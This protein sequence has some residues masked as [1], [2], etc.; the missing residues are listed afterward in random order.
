MIISAIVARGVNHVIGIN[1]NLPWHLPKD[2]KWFKEKTK[3]HHVIMG[4]KSFDSLGQPLPQRVNIVITRDR[5]FAHTGV[6]VVHTIAEA[7]HLAAVAGE[8]EAFILGGGKIYKQ[9]VDLWDRLYLT[10]V[11]ASPEGDTFFP[12]IDDDRYVTTYEEHHKQDDRH[13]Y[14]FVFKILERK[15]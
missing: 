10:E 3:G 11:A 9:T 14:D 4:R 1:N 6:E 13:A 7:L 12:L 5:N 8:E 15:R 2:L